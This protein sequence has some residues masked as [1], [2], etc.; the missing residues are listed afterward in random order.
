MYAGEKIETATTLDLFENVRHP[1]T[2]ALLASIPKP[3]PG[4]VPGALLDPGPAAGPP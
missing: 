2:E 1:Y 3:Q 4:Q